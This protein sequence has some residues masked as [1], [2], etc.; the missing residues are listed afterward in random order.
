MKLHLL[1]IAAMIPGLEAADLALPSVN[2]V[3]DVSSQGA[4]VPSPSPSHPAYFRLNASIYDGV[5][6][7][8]IEQPPE[9][10]ALL[11][12]NAMAKQN[13]FPARGNQAPDLVLSVVYGTVKP[14]IYFKGAG[15]ASH[16]D[17]VM[18]ENL[19]LSLQAGDRAATL[20]DPLERERL[21]NAIG[22]NKQHFIVITAFDGRSLA[23]NPE[24]VVLWR[25]RASMSGAHVRFFEAMRAMISDG[26][27]YFGRETP[28]RRIEYVAL[29]DA[30]RPKAGGPLLSVTSP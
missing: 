25:A 10:I 24:P 30:D 28:P 1:L 2:V 15:D 18:N 22:R 3:V 11:L 21:L 14:R 4:L 27:P 7:N 17:Q 16:P 29:A 12:T 26:V 19:I 20:V 6:A 5:G 13:Y 8:R 23:K 9:K